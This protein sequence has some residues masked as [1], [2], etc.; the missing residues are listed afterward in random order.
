M[1]LP[2]GAADEHWASL[3]RWFTGGGPLGEPLLDVLEPPLVEPDPLLVDPL[4]PPLLDP[5]EPLVDPLEP[6][7]EEPLPDPLLPD[8]PELPPSAPASGAPAAIPPHP[9]R[10]ERSA[11]ARK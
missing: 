7:V 3:G 9:E 5:P 8:P 4:E 11:I 6:P 1:Q 2:A 10:M